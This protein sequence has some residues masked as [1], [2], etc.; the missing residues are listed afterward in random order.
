MPQRLLIQ[1]TITSL[2]PGGDGV[3]HAELGGQRRAVFIPHSAPGDVLWAAVDPSGRPARGRMLELLTRGPDRVTPACPWSTRCGGCDWMHLS[4]D[5]QARTHAEHVRA[6]LPAEW[7]DMPVVDHTAPDAL[8]YRTRARVHVRCFGGGVDVGMHE[9][10]TH[11]PVNVETCAV[12]EPTLERA[13]RSL[14]AL[15]QGSRGRGQV[16]IALGAGRTPVLDVRWAGQ[17]A[18]IC[19]ARLEQAVIARELAGARVT[20]GEASRPAVIGDPTPWMIGADGGP[21]RLAPG[22]FAQASE[23]ASAMLAR[24]VAQIVHPWDVDRAVELYAGA[25][26]LSVL[27]AREVRDLVLV[28][29]NRDA[30]DAARANLASRSIAARV[31][32]ADAESYA[33]SAAT[34]LVVL[35]P[36]R[37][38]ARAVAQRLASSRVL[39]V[40]YVSCDP[41]TLGRDLKTLA[42]VYDVRSV[43]TLQMFPQ[44]SHVETVVALERKRGTGARA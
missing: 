30:C 11:D 34:R 20:M 3:A 19:F 22:G 24:C 8:G 29:S 43:A 7:R 2:A 18:A 4:L 23:G 15:F 13:R 37:T 5:T 33:W 14:A 16:Q 31:V 35:D 38:G 10:R 12:L 44:T 26:S 36:P 21:L 41:Q 6:A 1:A 27:L 25:G 32:E 28:E 42:P 9:S 39:Y 40:V 17:L